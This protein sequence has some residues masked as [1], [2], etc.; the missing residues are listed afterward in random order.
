[1]EVNWSAGIF[2]PHIPKQ[3]EKAKPYQINKPQTPGFLLIVGTS[4]CDISYL[5]LTVDVSGGN[6]DLSFMV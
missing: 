4:G 3:C 1:M 2:L 5:F 6:A